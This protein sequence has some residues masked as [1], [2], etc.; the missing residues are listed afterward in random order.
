M[1][2][3]HSTGH[4]HGAGVALEMTGFRKVLSNRNFRALWIGQGI[5]GIGDWV[6]VDW[7]D[8]CFWK[9]CSYDVAH[10]L[11]ICTTAG[12]VVEET[13]Q[14]LTLAFTVDGNQAQTASERTAIPVSAITKLRKIR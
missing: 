3:D 12:C 11:I 10:G 1:S 9:D 8:A 5:S 2:H 7:L 14:Y 4:N 13:R 6:I